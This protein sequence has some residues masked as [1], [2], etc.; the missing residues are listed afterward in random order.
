MTQPNVETV[1]D[2]EAQE[3]AQEYAHAYDL[4]E[5]APGKDVMIDRLLADR[6]RDKE[7]IRRLEAALADTEGLT[8]QWAAL[9]GEPEYID[10][11][12]YFGKAEAVLAHLRRAAGLRRPSMPRNRAR[13][14]GGHDD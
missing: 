11:S 7:R 14:G 13:N 8:R 10:A 4:R 3:W 2:A 1:S 6:A 5:L 9:T 12:R